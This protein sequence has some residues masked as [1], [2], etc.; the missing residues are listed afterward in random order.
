MYPLRLGGPERA[1]SSGECLPEITAG[2]AAAL[3]AEEKMKPDKIAFVSGFVKSL[4]VWDVT[5][6]KVKANVVSK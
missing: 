6:K 2:I 3:A 5:M 1:A 4:E